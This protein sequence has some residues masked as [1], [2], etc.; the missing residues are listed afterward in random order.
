MRILFTSYPQY[1]HINPMMPLALEAQ[2]AGHD[3][4]FATGADMAPYLE[5]WGLDVWSVGPTHA[6]ASAKIPPSFRYFTDTA[7]PRAVDLLARVRHWPPDLVV[8]D[9]FELAAAIAAT[10][11]DAGLIIH[12]LGLMIPAQIWEPAEPDIAEL[13]QRWNVPGGV[14]TVRDALHLEATPPMLRLDGERIWRHTQPLRPAPWPA[15]TDELLPAAIDRLP[16][17]DT[18]HL[19]LG[20]L[21]HER[22]GV[23]ET[24][25]D[26]LRSLEANLVVTTGP[27]S[28]P[29]RF[30]PQPAHVV[31]E[32]Y[33]PHAL[34]LPRCRLVVSQGGAGIMLGALAHGLPQL[35]LPQ[36]ADQFLQRAGVHGSR[37]RPRA[38]APGSHSRKRHD[39]RPTPAPRTALHRRRRHDRTASARCQAPTGCS[40]GSWDLPVQDRWRATRKHAHEGPRLRP[41]VR[42]AVSMSQRTRALAAA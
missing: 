3:V 30:G 29:T 15:T 25:I 12:G 13:Y 36:G 33:L 4:A 40:P 41:P 34:L 27:D 11:C 9:E 42:F 10:A 16:Y 32:S 35:M 14:A 26:G 28:D 19:T 38:P 20:T 23:L 2:R 7:E 31:I 22:S 37:R 6:E 8:A 21:F 5:R 18:I 1:G 17:P 39:S 24:A